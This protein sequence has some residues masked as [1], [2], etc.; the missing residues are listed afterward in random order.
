MANRASS[1]RRWRCSGR[2]ADWCYNFLV[3]PIVSS[4]YVYPVKSCRGIEITSAEVGARGIEHDREWMIVDAEGGFLTQR[5]L[6][7]LALIS[8]TLSDDR[9][10]LTFG[11]DRV[12][13]PFEQDS[14]RELDVDV[15][16][17][18]CRATDEGDDAAE[19][20]SM[21]LGVECR[22]VRM[23]RDNVRTVKRHHEQL[24]FADAYPFLITSEASLQDL[25]RR[26]NDSLPMERFRPN[27][28]ATGCE[29]YDEDRWKLIRINSVA[30][31]G[32]TRCVRCV[33]TTTDQ[34]TGER[35]VE[36]LAMLATY[37]KT[38]EGIVFGRNFSHLDTGTISVGDTIQVLE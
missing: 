21:F 18:R 2:A 38:R 31:R 28:V 13:V 16:G 1:R 14:G 26:L 24:A 4:L 3:Q 37:R 20:L 36:P 22:L 34:H 25:N 19:K 10:A 5:K 7:E 32:E 17:V 29:P 27:V 30:L 23:T 33:I 11:V 8:T 15:W 6:P 12:Q 35:G 9:L